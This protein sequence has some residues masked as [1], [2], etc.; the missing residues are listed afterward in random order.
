ME[1][2]Y[3]TTTLRNRLAVADGRSK[4]GSSKI[5]QA[6]RMLAGMRIGWWILEQV[7]SLCAAFPVPCKVAFTSRKSHFGIVASLCRNWKTAVIA[8]AMLLAPLESRA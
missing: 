4:V 3:S 2:Q 1:L 8:P 6:E 7:F 5:L